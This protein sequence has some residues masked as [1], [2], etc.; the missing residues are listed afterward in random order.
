MRTKI[1]LLSGEVNCS[2]FGCMSLHYVIYDTF[3]HHLLTSYCSDATGALAACEWSL[4]S[5]CF[6]NSRCLSFLQAV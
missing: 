2:V 3:S 6:S 1:L 5:L 4:V